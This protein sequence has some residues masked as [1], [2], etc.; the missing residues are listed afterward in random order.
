MYSAT[1]CFIQL[2]LSTISAVTKQIVVNSLTI[3]Y[4]IKLLQAAQLTVCT[5]VRGKTS[6]FLL[7]SANILIKE[8]FPISDCLDIAA[9]LRISVNIIDG[10]V[11]EVLRLNVNH[12]KLMTKSSST[13]HKVFEYLFCAIKSTNF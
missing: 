10:G 7:M 9:S 12:F 8:R 1:D 5:V 4:S 6:R 3:Q 2:T 11:T 13:S